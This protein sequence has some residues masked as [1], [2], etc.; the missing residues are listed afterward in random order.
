MV[1]FTALHQTYLLSS[2]T[3]WKHEMFQLNSKIKQKSDYKNWKWHHQFF[4]MLCI[5]HS[6]KYMDKS[7]NNKQFLTWPNLTV[8]YIPSSPETIK[9]HWPMQISM[10]NW[11]NLQHRQRHQNIQSWPQL[12]LKFEQLRQILIHKIYQSCRM[13]PSSIICQKSK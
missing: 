8:K 5:F 3:C 7:I 11:V 12:K 13:I 4:A 9:C 2:L 1:N 10:H 6:N